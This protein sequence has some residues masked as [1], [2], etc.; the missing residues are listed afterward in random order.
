MFGNLGK[1]SARAP[2]LWQ[3]DPALE[4]RFTITER[5]SLRFRAEAFNV[6]NRQQ[7]GV[8]VALLNAGNFGQIVSS[9]NS[10]ATGSGTPRNLQFMLRLEY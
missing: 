6:L 9:V 7:I 1:N 5:S 8:P 10:N 4:K 2:G 3:I